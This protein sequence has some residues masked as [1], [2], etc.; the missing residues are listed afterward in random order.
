MF[1]ELHGDSVKENIE[2]YIRGAVSEFAEKGITPKLAVI[3]A[4]DDDGQIYYESAIIRQ[5]ELYGIETQVI[6]FDQNISQALL[7]VALQAVNEDEGVHG[8]IL[9]RPF[10]D[11]IDS[12]RLR[13]MLNPAKDV[14]AIT[15]ISMA[16]LFVGKEDALDR[17]SVV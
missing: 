6:S 12:E 3:R 13:G 8:I 15:D 5:S 11:S 2:E 16:E 9:L 14:D 10:P 7:E 1:R 4:G 17:K